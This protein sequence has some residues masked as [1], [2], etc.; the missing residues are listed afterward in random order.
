M[1]CLGNECC[2]RIVGRRTKEST[3]QAMLEPHTTT[4]G[5]GGTPSPR[6]YGAR[7]FLLDVRTD[8]PAM[9]FRITEREVSL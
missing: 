8:I 5:D 6:Q 4:A 9:S 7:F 1:Y 2:F 3:K